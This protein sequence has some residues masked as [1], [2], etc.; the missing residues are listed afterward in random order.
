VHYGNRYFG[1]ILRYWHN[2]PHI[3]QLR[4]LILQSQI[5]ALRN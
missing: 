5:H 3:K 2:L 4:F 1:D